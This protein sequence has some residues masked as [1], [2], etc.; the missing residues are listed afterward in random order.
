MI[1]RL[2]TL[3]LSVFLLAHPAT[4]KNFS[5]DRI[6]VAVTGTGADV[7]LIPGL[8]SSPD[9]WNGT[10]AAVPGYRYHLVK[11]AGFDG[12]PAGGNASGPVLIP[13]ADEIARYIKEAGLKSPA[14][15]GH[16]MGGSFAMLVA[17][18]N[19]GIASKV[20]VVDMM[21]FLGAMFG[22]PKATPESVVPM[23][24]QIREG[25][26]RSAGDARKKQIEGT[27]ASMVKTETMRPSAVAQ[28]L[29]SDPA[30]SGQGMY[31]L[32]VTDLRPD[33]AKITVPLTVLWV[34]PQG[35][36]LTQPQMDGYYRASYAGAPQAVV[37]HIPD[38]YHFIM[39]DQPELFQAELKAF[40]A[41][42]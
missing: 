18:R 22:G 34:V 24:T 39:Y 38:S 21:P 26:A 11:V 7:V 27:I 28:S 2:L 5:S 30:V 10:V 33:L 36:P 31:D 41:A 1:T 3:L 42:K 8:S 25:I 35:A 6:S 17:G 20:M 4:A 40:L 14:L 37:K 15:V 13:V 16:S 12:A 19:E 29:A 32:I 9:V 23:A